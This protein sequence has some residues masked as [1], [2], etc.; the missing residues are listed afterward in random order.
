MRCVATQKSGPPSSERVPQTA[1]KYSNHFG[2]VYDRCV[3]VARLIGANRAFV[4]REIP[5]L[6]RLLAPDPAAALVGAEAVVVGH[7]GGDEVAAIIAAH[8]AG[9]LAG[10]LIL[11]LQGVE[12]LARLPGVTY[13][14]I[15]W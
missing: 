2:Q 10:A 13:E 15:C 9:A 6:E 11:D 5:H 8:E 4:A 12:E 3:K 7:V 1:R 14:G